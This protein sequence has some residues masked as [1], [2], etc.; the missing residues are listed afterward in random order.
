VTNFSKNGPKIIRWHP[1][2]VGRFLI[3]CNSGIAAAMSIGSLA[4]SRIVNESK[5][6]VEDCQWD[7][8]S[9]NYALISYSDGSMILADMASESVLQSFEV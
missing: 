7:P 5:L 4:L 1:A 3:G 9:E 2:Q 6:A 8:L